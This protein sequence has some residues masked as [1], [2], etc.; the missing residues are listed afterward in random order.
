[1]LSGYA[2]QFRFDIFQPY[3]ASEALMLFSLSPFFFFAIFSPPPC[4]SRRY[5]VLLTLM[6]IIF[7]MPP[8][9]LSITPQRRFIDDTAITPAMPLLP[10]AFLPRAA[11]ITPDDGF[12]A[13]IFFADG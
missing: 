3:A 10:A 7:A 12:A 9:L 4:F 8:F 6:M 2:R 11:A 1:M 5:A 13:V